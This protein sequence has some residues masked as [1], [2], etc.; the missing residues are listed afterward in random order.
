M[1]SLS[2]V[3]PGFERSKLASALEDLRIKEL[4]AEMIYQADNLFIKQGAALF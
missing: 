2:F 3:R 1:D 4:A